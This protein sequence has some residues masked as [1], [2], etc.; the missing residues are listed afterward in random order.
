MGTPVFSVLNENHTLSDSRIEHCE[1]PEPNR[2]EKPTVWPKPAPDLVSFQGDLRRKVFAFPISAGVS[3]PG[4][5]VSSN[6]ASFILWFAF[7]TFTLFGFRWAKPFP[8]PYTNPWG[9]TFCSLRC[10]LQFHL[11]T[12]LLAA[13]LRGLSCCTLFLSFP[14]GIKLVLV[15][16]WNGQLLWVF[17][18]DQ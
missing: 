15:G 9:I 2:W 16:S 8:Q 13:L 1:T 4:S 18:N 7:G 5:L 3:S 17:R 11:T 10:F 14:S 12:W 6:F